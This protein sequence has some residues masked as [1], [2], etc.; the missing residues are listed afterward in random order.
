MLPH[1]V[2]VDTLS[3]NQRGDGIF[4]MTL[5]DLH[6]LAGTVKVVSRRQ[7]LKHLGSRVSYVAD[8]L[9]HVRFR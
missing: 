5:Q 8:C 4:R 3:G 6:V 9:F 7:R 1:D 2:E